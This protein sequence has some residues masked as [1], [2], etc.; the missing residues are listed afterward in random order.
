LRTF[1][2]ADLAN[3]VVLIR[4]DL[5]VPMKNGQILDQ[6]RIDRFLPTLDE[7]LKQKAR[8]ILMTHLGRPK[9][10]VV[11]T[12]SLKPIADRLIELGYQVT[13]SSLE[14]MPQ[15][16]N[17]GQICLLENLR[18]YEGEES[19]DPQ[20]AQQLAALGDV[21]INDA[22]SVSHRAHA[23]VEGITHF[24][25]SFAGPQLAS[26][27]A[28]LS[29]AFEKPEQPLMAI[30]AGAKVSTK[31]GLLKSLS[32]KVDTLVVAGGLAHTFLSAK[33]YGVGSES[34]S[35]EGMIPLCRE[36]LETSKAEL[37]LPKDV[38]V[39]K[40]VRSGETPVNVPVDAIPEDQIIV[41]MG[42]ETL[43]VVKQ[44]LHQSRTLI[45]NGVV[46]IFEVSPFDQ[47]S[48]EIAR[49]V[50][51]RTQE[52]H[53]YSVSGGG[54]TIAGLNKAGVADQLSYVST[55]GGA[56]LE[57]LEGKSL[58]GVKALE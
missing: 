45:W 35:E 4:A 38:K 6:T 34:L 28:V 56:F 46:G 2:Q 23:S 8:V 25:P 36:I 26:E 53:L 17:P 48:L 49:Y 29:K 50:A 33:G 51:K 21:Y 1:H 30:V 52:G 40:A 10:K 22:F 37:V 55:A 20:F 3:K 24:I 47:A 31:L 5:N 18:F 39:A 54:E 14:T 9:G 27:V 41:D 32:Q 57:F 13:L 43:K 12:L 58:P 15:E 7:V 44:K 11:E 42:D 19:N 16:I